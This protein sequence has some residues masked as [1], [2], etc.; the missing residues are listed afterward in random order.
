M[1]KLE[2]LG[3]S[4]DDLC[5]PGYD[6]SGSSIILQKYPLATFVHYCSHVLNLSIASSCS[7]VLVR[8]MM[9]IISEVSRFFEHGKRQDKLVEVI[10]CKLPEAKKNK[11]I[12]ENKGGG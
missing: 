9:G 1:A 3:L 2:E 11:T 4:C 8:N 10:E 7:E 6:G 5:G 12:M